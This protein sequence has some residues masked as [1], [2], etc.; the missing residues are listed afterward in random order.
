MVLEIL[1]FLEETP[2]LVVAKPGERREVSLFVILPDRVGIEFHALALLIV[3][4][5]SVKPPTIRAHVRG[6]APGSPRERGGLS[7]LF[8]LARR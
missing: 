6:P 4:P 3:T 8:V 2:H 5:T 7:L 1:E